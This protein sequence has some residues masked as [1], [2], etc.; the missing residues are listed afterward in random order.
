[1]LLVFESS[2]SFHFRSRE[3]MSGGRAFWIVGVLINRV[4][5]YSQDVLLLYRPECGDKQTI[6]IH[7][8]LLQVGEVYR[9]HR[10]TFYLAAEFIDRYLTKTRN[11]QKQQLQL[12]GV[13]ALFVAAKLEVR[14]AVDSFSSSLVEG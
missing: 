5:L 11:I 12:I 8:M 4:S 10:E 2:G 9:L 1:M 7:N 6:I 3:L 13:T 14:I